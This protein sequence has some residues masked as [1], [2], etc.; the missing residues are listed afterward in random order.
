MMLN[1]NRDTGKEINWK[2]LY[3][4]WAVGAQGISVLILVLEVDCR[5]DG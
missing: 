1:Y 4:E 2:L 5:I 3:W